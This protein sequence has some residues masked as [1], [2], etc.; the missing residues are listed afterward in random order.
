[1]GCRFP[2]NDLITSLRETAEGSLASEE[3]AE[4][5]EAVLEYERAVSSA[6]LDTVPALVIVL[7]PDFKVLRFNRSCELSTGYR[8]ADLKG[9]QIW[10][11]LYA[12]EDADAFR[13]ALQSLRKNPRPDQFESYCRTL[14]GSRLA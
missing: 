8:F 6:I 3:R 9:K 4:Q 11:L 14:D 5:A 1:M 13:A 12:D 2:M 7:D 10:P